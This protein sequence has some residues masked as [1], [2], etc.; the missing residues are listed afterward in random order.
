MDIK[1]SKKI[2]NKKLNEK[3]V[4]IIMSVLDN[5]KMFITFAALISFT[6]NHK[7]IYS[8]LAAL[9]VQ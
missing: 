5:E 3:Y 9:V 7:S 8:Y 4:D 6:N 2:I 1:E